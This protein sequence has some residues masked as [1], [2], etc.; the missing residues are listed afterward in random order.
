DHSFGGLAD[1]GPDRG[2]P[3]SRK[4]IP[5]IIAPGNA[6]FIIGG[7]IDVSR[8]QFPDRR[9]HEHNPQLTAVRTKSEDLRKVADHLAANVREAKG[10][11]RVFTPSGGFSSHDST[12][13]HSM[14]TTVPAPFAE[15]SQ[16]VMPASAPVTV[17][18][19]HFNDEAFADAIIAAARELSEAK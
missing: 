10:P 18:D 13:G 8:V 15:Y 5:T 17:I 14:D 7:P 2:R 3:A 1:T 9:Y 19:A 16:Q 11:V 4:G 12:S 6:D